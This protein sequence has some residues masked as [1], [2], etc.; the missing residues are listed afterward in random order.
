MCHTQ[1]IYLTLTLLP[2]PTV[3]APVEKVSGE[4]DSHH[5]SVVDEGLGRKREELD[6]AAH[7]PNE[8]EVR[9]EGHLEGSGV[10][11][12]ALAEHDHGNAHHAERNQCAK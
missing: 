11:G 2:E 1:V 8:G 6:A 12:V 3:V 10:L 4:A 5:K 7:Q 9:H